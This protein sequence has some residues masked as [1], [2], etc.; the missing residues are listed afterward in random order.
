MAERDGDSGG[1]LEEE[2]GEGGAGVEAGDRQDGM[3]GIIGPSV[4]LITGVRVWDKSGGIG[5]MA[6]IFH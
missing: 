4:R 6:S 1:G 2:D 5:V 3:G